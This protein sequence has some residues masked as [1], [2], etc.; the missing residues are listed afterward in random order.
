MGMDN[1]ITL[2]HS[3]VVRAAHNLARQIPEGSKLYG[4]PRGGIPVAYLLRG[5]IPKSVIVAHPDDADCVVDDLIDS[6]R[7]RRQYL[8]KPFAVLYG[9]PDHVL[10][11]LIG[12]FQVSDRWL[13][14]PWESSI[15]GS[16]ED[17]CIRLLQLIG[18][19][20][21][22]EGLRET[23]ARFIRAWQEWT[24]GYSQK[25]EDV[26]KTFEDGAEDYDQMVI[27]DPI[28]FYSQC[29]HHLAPVFGTAHIA[30]IPNKKIVGLSKLVRLTNIFAR[31]LQVQARLT[32]QIANALMEHLQPLGVG[33]VTR[34]RHLC[35][36]S[37]GIKSMG[38]ETTKIALRGA[39]KEKHETRMEFLTMIKGR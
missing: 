8:N 20:V 32:T 18:E 25:P 14:F 10:E 33:V 29:E 9:K 37:R 4:V 7:T 23:P 5:M 1:T 21:N 38:S 11:T 2:S 30:Y 17:I 36:E 13:V 28:P 35:M 31:R 12:E 6:G 39:M 27:V 3:D 34:A 22:R 26:L 16:A 15:G 24:E 19:D